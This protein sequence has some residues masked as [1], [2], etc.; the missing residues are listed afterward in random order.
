[1][2]HF[3]ARGLKAACDDL[4]AVLTAR[5]EPF[6]QRGKRRWQNENADCLGKNSAHLLRALPVY[7]QQDVMTALHCAL[8]P[9]FRSAVVI[10]MHFGV[11]QK[12]TLFEHVRKFLL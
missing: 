10:P 3:D 12:L 2:A 4:G 9:A 1:M 5:F 8:N 11:L 7:F 6:F